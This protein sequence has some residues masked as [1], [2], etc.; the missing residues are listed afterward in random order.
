MS[1][2]HSETVPFQSRNQ[3]MNSRSDN[4]NGIGQ[5]GPISDNP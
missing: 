4:Y 2:V 5:F 1:D 3:S